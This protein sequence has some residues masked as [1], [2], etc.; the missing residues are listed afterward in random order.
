MRKINNNAI[1]IYRLLLN[2]YPRSYLKGYKNLM[3][4]TF[5]DM[6]KEDRNLIVWLK[7]VKELP[8]SLIQEHVENIKGGAMEITKRNYNL[9]LAVLIV[10]YITLVSWALG[11]FLSVEMGLGFFSY[12][13]IGFFGLFLLSSGILFIMSLVFNVK[14]SKLNHQVSKGLKFTLISIPPIAFC[15][16]AILVKGLTEG[17]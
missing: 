13:T 3:E 6:L 15:Y 2:L 5:K 7:V 11:I 12:L 10:G 14:E 16:L 9:G 1:K 8:G 4:Q 17:H